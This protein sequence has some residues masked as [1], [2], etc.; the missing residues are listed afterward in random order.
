MYSRRAVTW[1]LAPDNWGTPLKPQCS[2]AL[3]NR[4]LRPEC[5]FVPV[6]RLELAIKLDFL[7]NTLN[8]CV[9]GTGPQQKA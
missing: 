2:G 9:T 6:E 1:Y 3:T 8:C 4:L 7:H 5:F